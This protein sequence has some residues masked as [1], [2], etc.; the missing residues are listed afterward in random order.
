M[1]EF[2]NNSEFR[3]QKL[4]E[5][6]KQLH[7]G[8]TVDEV[9]DEFQK[10]FG[11]VSTTEISQIEQALV[12]EGLPIEEVQKLC[13]VH[14]TVFKGSISDIH[15]SKDYS[16]IIGHPVNILVE[17]NKAIEKLIE[18]EIKPHY[19]AYFKKPNPTSHLMLR[20]GFER[21]MEIEHHYS[22]KEYAFFPF[23]EKYEITAPPKVMWG[24]DDEIRAELKEVNKILSSAIID[25]DDLKNKI[26]SVL[27]KI[28][29]MIY[30]ENNILI[31]LFSDTFSFYDWIKID[32]SSEEF[33]YCLVKPL[34]PWK[35]EK[36]EEI[37]DK[38]TKKKVHTDEV[39]FDAG[40]MLPKEINAIFNTLPIDITFVDKD[41]K[42][43]YFS[44][45][46]ERIF[47]RPKTIIGR[48]VSLC[49]P[50]ASVHVVDKIVDSFKSGEKDHEDFWIQ[51]GEL[52]VVIKYYAVRDNEGNYLGTLE[53]T[54][55]IKPLRELTGEKR[56]LDE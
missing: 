55:N 10:H 27:N 43:K 28:T 18:E 35:M 32:E 11:S 6:I 30:K 20:I 26:D 29:E 38:E 39:E 50:P 19:D 17:E 8:K 7:Q 5:L 37:N 9:K 44:Q 42:V 12:K 56:L 14:A 4:K 16:K 31:P 23:L 3:Q 46:K 13:D 1:S 22:R 48:D 36:P 33:G 15:A 25:N 51:K 21:I 34:H 2:I 49:H 41:N 40:F 52:F 47:Q 53:V 24:V 54:Q 45:A